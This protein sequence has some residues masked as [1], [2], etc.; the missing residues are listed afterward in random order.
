MYRSWS[1]FHCC[2]VL[3]FITIITVFCYA[4]LS[5]DAVMYTYVHIGRKTPVIRIVKG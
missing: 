4:A 5:P 1:D 3:T 2:E